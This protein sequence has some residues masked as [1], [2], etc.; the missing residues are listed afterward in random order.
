SEVDAMAIM[1]AQASAAIIN[2]RLFEQLRGANRAKDEFL[3]ILSH[4]LRTP[5]TPILGWMHLLRRFAEWDPLLSQGIEAIERN[6]RQLAG[7]IN[8]LLD[9]SRAVSGKIE[10]SRERTD[11]RALVQSAIKD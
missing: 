5:L 3:A 4:E 11:L 1:A 10:L 6:A 8:D 2:A 9:L 7:L